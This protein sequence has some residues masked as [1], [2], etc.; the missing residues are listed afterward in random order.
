MI[1]GVGSG[2]R[3]GTSGESLVEGRAPFLAAGILLVF[4]VF[5]A[6]L[7]QLQIM[8]SADLRERSQRNSVRTITLEAP[9]GDIVD[10]D[11]RLLATTRPAFGLNVLPVELRNRELTFAAIG[12]LLDTD[13][14][15][16]T[17]RVGVPKG[18][19]RFKPVHLA[20][21]LS[22][23]RLVRIESHLYALPGVLTDIQPRRHYVG[24][25]LAAHMLGLIGE[26]GRKQL[27][28]PEFEGYR[29]GEVVGKAGV[30]ILLQSRL[31]GRA[32]GR[33]L[34]V[35]VSGRSIE[36]IDEMMPVPGGT[37]TLTL[38]IDLQRVAEE[39]F[40]PDVL[41][42]RAKMG[43][44]VALDPRTGD[45]LALVSKPSYDPN[46]F[47]GGVDS[48][49]WARL[50]SDQ[51]R[52]IQNRAIAGQ[53]PP[54][55]TYKAI[56]AAAALEEGLVS[57]EEK[58]YCPGHFRLG[59]RTYRCWKRGGHGEVDLY[60]ALVNSC[61]VFFYTVGL[62]VGIDK[63]AEYARGFNLGQRTGIPLANELAGLV[64]TSS[65]K[66]RRFKEVWVRGETVSAA[67]GQ[68][69]N[70]VTPLQL[71]VA[72][73]AIGNGGK[74][75]QPRVVLQT[76]DMQGVVTPGPAPRLLREIPV[77]PKNL[78]IVRA[79]L[80][81]VVNDP[82]GTGRRSRVPGVLV[83]GKTGTSQVVSLEHT[84]GL[85]EEDVVL[86]H[87]DHAWYAAFAPAKNAEIAVAV[88]VEHG[89]SGGSTAAPVAQK[90]LAK[91]FEKKRAAERL[92]VIEPPAVLEASGARAGASA[93]LAA[94]IP[95]VTG[96]GTGDDRVR[97]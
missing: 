17:E 63:L 19:D 52:P 24:G 92:P 39:A 2:G 45:I 38:D 25:E 66:E 87:R 97:D 76:R 59:R 36:V 18:R 33:N 42:E 55:S 48:E 31:R 67:I 89:G 12:Q 81:G 7:F 11:G 44:L 80:E 26:I 95:T 27:E 93:T 58:I 82:V 32:G 15:L 29:S 62:R 22:Y 73:G 74:L 35:D 3:L 77:S 90:V 41:G 51:W 91:Y 96:P 60:E 53:Y 56:V 88:I 78:E 49:T 21:D 9:R 10:R 20:D 50:T 75:M 86:E 47:A 61:D 72:F 64:P 65:W 84:E 70:L 8:E 34:V 1:G 30:E 57:P 6:R 68:G 4:G 23:D 40:L 79:G 85:E 69:F 16:L 28:T 94:A 13:P 37:A 46:D 54:G 43:A 83:A 71:A 14:A 5:V